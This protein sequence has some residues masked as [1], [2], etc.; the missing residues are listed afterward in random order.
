MKLLNLIIF[1]Y[2]FTFTLA[3]FDNSSSSDTHTI[4]LFSN[5]T[6][7]SEN[8]TS[9]NLFSVVTNPSNYQNNAWFTYITNAGIIG[10]GSLVVMGAGL[11]FRNDLILLLGLFGVFLSIG[12][13]SLISIY[14]FI[15]RQSALFMCS[16]AGD[17]CQA[18]NFTAGMITGLI[19][20]YYVFLCIEWWSG[21][22]LNQ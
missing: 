21:R 19:T 16:P 17:I 6:S 20:L 9:E 5:G 4:Q 1:M 15:A 11:V 22:Q 14:N 2:L 8:I 10:I 12:A 18:S 13:V 3:F 7:A